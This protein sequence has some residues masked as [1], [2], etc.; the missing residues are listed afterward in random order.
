LGGSPSYANIDAVNSVLQIDT[1]GTTVTGGT[2]MYA[3]E[4]AK[5][6]SKVLNLLDAHIK[7]LPGETLT[8]SASS[9]SASDIS[10]TVRERELF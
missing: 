9:A 6:E 3:L 1:A 5:V 4:L 8:V 10:I 2:L 7:M